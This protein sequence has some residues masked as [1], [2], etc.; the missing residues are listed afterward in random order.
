MLMDDHI[1]ALLDAL[2]SAQRGKP[3]TNL[4]WKDDH[5]L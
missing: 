4:T 3:P 5:P 1:E 2:R